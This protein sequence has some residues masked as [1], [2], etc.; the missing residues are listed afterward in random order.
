M[1]L[2]EQEI[3]FPEKPDRRYA[4]VSGLP[5]KTFKLKWKNIPKHFESFVAN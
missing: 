5:N 2:A 4:N 3:W 1:S